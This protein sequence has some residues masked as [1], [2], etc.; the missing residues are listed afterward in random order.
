MAISPDSLLAR[1]IGRWVALCHERAPVV[2]AAALAVSIGAGAYLV[3]NI[4]IDTDTEDMLSAELPFRQNAVALDAAFPEQENNILVVVEGRNADAVADAAD[5]M[6][7]AMRARPGT[8]GVVFAP[9]TEPFLQRNGLLY[10][11]I[12]DLDALSAR[13]AAAQPFLGTL[14][15][16]PNLSGLADMLALL[17][18]G[19]ALD[20]PSEAEAARVV[21][22]IAEVAAAVGK[23]EPGRLVWTDL[24][25]GKT[26]TPDR[27]HRRLIVI[28]P[29]LD[30]ASLQP[31]AAAMDAVS[32][33]AARLG[34]TAANG[35]AV[36]LTGSA[37]LAEDELR[38]VEE[39]MGL[40]GI[41]SLVL[42][43][44][45][46]ALGLRSP[47][48]I[49]A[50]LLTL[51]VGLL[52]TAALAILVFGRLNLISVAFAVLFVGL[53]VDFGIH[54]ILRAR[55]HGEPWRVSLPAA[56]AGVGP[57]LLLCAVTTALAFM[58]FAPTDYIGLAELGTIS[59]MGMG[60][61]LVANLTLLPALTRY[62][63][64]KPKPLPLSDGA[65]GL[66]GLLR[67]RAVLVVGI[68]AMTAVAAAAVSPGA[69]FDFDPMNLRSAESPSVRTL[70][71]L[72]ES[73]DAHPYTLDI[74]AA[75]MAAARDT[76][77]KVQALPSVAKAESLWS[78]V[79]GEQEEKADVV[80]GMALFLGP[81]FSQPAGTVALSDASLAEARKRLADN[82]ATLRGGKGALAEAA[83]KLDAALAG[84]AD[85][86]KINAAVFA[87]LPGRLNALKGSLDAQ[88]FG[89]G[90][91]PASL[92]GRYAAKDGRVRVEVSPKA[93]MR[94]ADALAAFAAEVKAV[95][96]HATGAPVIIVEAGRA[97]VGTFAEALS[98]SVAGIA[99]IL[100][101][102]L[103]RFRDVVLVFAPVALAA[104]WTVAVSAVLDLPF[105]F[106][107]VIVLPLLFGISVDFGTHMV[108][109]ER[110]TG[111]A[112][113]VATSTPRAVLLSALTTLGSF[114]SIML[115]GHPGTASMG[116]LLTVA[117]LLSLAA[118]LLVLPAL[119]A[120]L[121]RGERG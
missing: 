2:L 107:N 74:L 4:R 61:A 12:D 92:A 39:G 14:W 24:L 44:G 57:A 60:V 113:T 16:A 75:D 77:T 29:R 15:R 19:G 6:A 42:V 95:A 18:E 17:R 1:T 69:R 34:A 99:V 5:A 27:T 76:A 41:L 64:G 65:T 37:A 40:A 70:F 108:L 110:E 116:A 78:L 35:L 56:G 54:F 79:P 96:P 3:Q 100:W 52:W 55:E 66:R 85:T 118:N 103:R 120:V 38:S 114:A 84:A 83:A 82:L 26:G 25:A 87:G 73:G 59:A 9:E 97:V 90:D 91:L 111:G 101:L 49:A 11:D 8:F 68:A 53:S 48:G 32:D 46:L 50:L 93:D 119:I 22:R 31:A 104:L 81:A 45:L 109:R 20:P 88:P 80:R 28:Q 121:A 7:A 43:L 112:G 98:I 72:I 105:N 51:I 36:R 23:G 115:S 63:G 13:L 71:D 58:S 21:G 33:I 10:L 67:R 117:I 89:V 30:F 94:N 106:A 102:V 47:G 62:L 86:G